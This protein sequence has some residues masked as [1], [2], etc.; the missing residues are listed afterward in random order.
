VNLTV[1]PLLIAA[2]L[3]MSGDRD[4]ETAQ[5]MMTG[6]HVL[7]AHDGALIVGE[8]AVTIPGGAQ[9]P[10]PIYVIGGQLIVRGAV[11]GDVIQLAGTVTVE[12]GARIGGELQHV[13]GTLVVSDDADI[14]R[15][16][17]LDLTRAPGDGTAVRYLSGAILVLLIA[18]VGFLLTKKRNAALDNLAAA[19]TGHPVAT[20]TV[21]VLLTLTFISVFVFM[22]MTLVLLPVAIAGLLAGLVTLGYGVIGWGHL[23]GNRLPIRHQRLSTVVGVVLVAIGIQ[24]AGSIPLVGDLIVAAVLL[25][26]LGAVVVTYYGVTRFRPAVLAG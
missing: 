7:E 26:G 5:L 8:A 20:L 23:L 2:L 14:G 22:A 16:T 10:G 18:G 15:R 9:V 25:I 24:L 4:V 3:M 17:S 21:G 19:V 1:I 13:A 11:M 12:S 6:N